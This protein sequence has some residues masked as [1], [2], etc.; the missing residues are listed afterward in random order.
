MYTRFRALRLDIFLGAESAETQ[1]KKMAAVITADGW[2]LWAMSDHRKD[3]LLGAFRQLLWPLVRILLRNG[4]SYGE[5]AETAK[6]VFVEVAAHDSGATGGNISSSRLAILTGLTRA[7]VERVS[8][9]LAHRTPSSNANLNRVG[10]ILAGWHQDPDF[11]GPYGLPLEL[12][13]AGDSNSFEALVLRYGDGSTQAVLDELEKI[14]S[15]LI[16]GGTRVRVLTRAYIPSES[17]PAGLQFM[18]MALTDLAETLDFNLNP[19]V[20]G[21]LFE[22]RVWTPAGIDP[23]DMPAFDAFV[24]AK[25]QQFLETLDNYLT[26]R[27][28]DAEKVPSSKKIR[29]GVGVYLFS[30]AHRKFRDE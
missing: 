24:H 7:E 19:D 13:I 8:D 15:V 1:N 11:T 16:T 14:G 27:E 9:Q 10:R 28:T 22:R 3:T 5:Y 4:V 6:T 18:G 30:D 20:D 29:V 17:D 23:L 21:G 12:P 26:A 2:P 25:G